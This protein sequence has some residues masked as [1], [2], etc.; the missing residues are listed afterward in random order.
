MTRSIVNTALVLALVIGALAMHPVALAAEAGDVLD[1]TDSFA[2]AGSGVDQLQV[3]E[4]GGI[5]IIRGRTTDKAHAA[6]L[7]RRAADL[8]YTR[9]ANLVRISEDNDARITRVAEFELSIHRNL[10]GCQFR[11]HSHRGVVTLAGRVRHE[12]QKDVAFQLLRSIHGVRSVEME[13]K[14]F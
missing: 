8:G 10:D 2:A 3:A 9:V 1:L 4:I 14:T 13:L 12:L 7:S 5:V 6:K 11:V